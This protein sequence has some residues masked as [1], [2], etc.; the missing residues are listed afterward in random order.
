MLSET[1]IHYVTGFLYILTRREDISIVLGEKVFN[2]ASESRRE[3]DIVI[4]T[5]AEHGLAGIEVKH[6]GRPLHVGIVEGICQ[7]FADMSS[8]TRRSIVSASGY[9][10]PTLRRPQAAAHGLQ[11]LKIVRGKVPP[12]ATIDLSH[13]TEILVSYLKWRNKSGWPCINEAA[14][15]RLGQ[16]PAKAVSDESS[17]RSG[18][19][20]FPFASPSLISMS[21]ART[22]VRAV[23]CLW[24]R[25]P[26]ALSDPTQGEEE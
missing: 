24:L 9:T 3:V 8:I 18:E 22:I 10:V 2:E 25:R 21:R 16:N 19:A 23:K 15:N 7:K 20:S 4:A 26:S 1:D 5:A 12:F 14:T 6:E 17:A 13:V 11:C